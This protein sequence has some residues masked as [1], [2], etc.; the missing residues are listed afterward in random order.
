MSEWKC[1]HLKIVCTGSTVSFYDL[2]Y[3]AKSPVFTVGVS[4]LSTKNLGVDNALIQGRISF[5]K[6]AIRAMPIATGVQIGFSRF[7]GFHYLPTKRK[8]LEEMLQFLRNLRK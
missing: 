6:S 5:G 8:T 1:G 4:D 2:Q 7:G 3:S